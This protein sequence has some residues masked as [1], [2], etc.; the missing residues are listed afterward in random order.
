MET[1]RKAATE[2]K[3]QRKAQGHGNGVGFGRGGLGAPREESF[4]VGFRQLTEFAT[5]I[6]Q[7]LRHNMAAERVKCYDNAHEDFSGI[8][9]CHPSVL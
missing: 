7:S 4:K 8:T 5:T 3:V 2:K 9:A 1:G 6:E